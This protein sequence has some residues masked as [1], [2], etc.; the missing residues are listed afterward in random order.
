[1]KILWVLYFGWLEKQFDDALLDTGK[2]MTIAFSILGQ[3][4]DQMIDHL[5]VKIISRQIK[6][7]Q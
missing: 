2:L 6:H 7:L 4:I 1:M 5:I 3:Y